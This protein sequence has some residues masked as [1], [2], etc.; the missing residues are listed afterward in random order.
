M[1]EIKNLHA[2]IAE[3]GTEIIRGL[4]LTVKAGEVAAI[5]GPNG[6]GKS[7]L[8]YILSGREDYEVTEGDILYNGES[9]LELDPAERAAK[10]IFLAFQYPVEIP[11]V[12]TMQ[13]LKVAMNEQ[14]KARGEAE[15]TTPDFMRRVKE[16]A[17]SLKIATGNAASVRSTS[18]SP[19]VRRSAPKSC[20][21]RCSSRSCA[22]S[23]RP[24]PVST[25]T[26]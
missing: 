19:A 14:R 24:I 10:G 26:R 6:S 17:A 20:R 16:A 2:R 7:T 12:A 1:L 15:L 22:F 3:D 23:T 9:I 11:G 18:A 13:F 21:C 5:M 25:S 4:N 8:S